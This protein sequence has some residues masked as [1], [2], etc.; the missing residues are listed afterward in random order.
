MLDLLQW[1]NLIFL[2]PLLCAGAYHLLLATGTVAAETDADADADASLDAGGGANLDHDLDHSVERAGVEAFGHRGEAA[3]SGL[4]DRALSVLGI[5]K[6][7]LSLVLVSWCYIWGVAGYASNLMFSSFL[8][9]ALYAWLSLGVAGAGALVL[10]RY[11]AGGLARVLPRT[12]TYGVYTADLVGRPAV[13]RYAVTP[14][15][16]TAQL[17]DEHGTMHEVDCRTRP[18]GTPIPSGTR[19]AL[20]EYDEARQVFIAVPI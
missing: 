13:V 3:E 19:V 4:L 15:F 6:V 17:Y 8:P 14:T 16:G 1:W 7:P 18:D 20:V 11:L 10:T 2:L 5:G 9:A 12:E